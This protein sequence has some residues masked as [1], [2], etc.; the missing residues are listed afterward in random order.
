MVDMPMP[1]RGKIWDAARDSSYPYR[2]D[3]PRKLEQELQQLSRETGAPRIAALEAAKRK[4]I[5]PINDPITPTTIPVSDLPVHSPVAKAKA[6]KAPKPEKPKRAVVPDGYVTI[7]DLAKTWGVAATDCRAA[8]R[9]SG[10]E[11]P[12]YGWAF[13]PK[14]LAKIKKLCGVK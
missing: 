2:Y 9:G 11:K 14:D 4:P 1:K 5:V 13:G 10:L 12:A 6:A 3:D 8:L 7:S